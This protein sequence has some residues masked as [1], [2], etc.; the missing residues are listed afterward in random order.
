MCEYCVNKRNNNEVVDDTC[1]HDLVN[2]KFK[3]NQ[4]NQSNP[5]IGDVYNND[6]HRYDQKVIFEHYIKRYVLY[7]Y[8][9]NIRSQKFN[10]RIYWKCRNPKY[11]SIVSDVNK[12]CGID[13]KELNNDSEVSKI[14]DVALCSTKFNRRIVYKNRDGEFNIKLCDFEKYDEFSKEQGFSLYGDHNFEESELV[15]VGFAT[16]CLNGKLNFNLR[17]HLLKHNVWDPDVGAV[18]PGGYSSSYCKDPTNPV[19][20]VN[21]LID[22]IINELRAQGFNEMNITEANMIRLLTF[23][24]DNFIHRNDIDI[25]TDHRVHISESDEYLP[26]VDINVD[27]NNNGNSSG[28]NSYDDIFNVDSE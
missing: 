16:L 19:D 23:A 7:G 20:E 4:G 21:E 1:R 25:T 9:N 15:N 13:Y 3:Y 5:E 27:D 18:V 26:F 6:T 2:E 11:V 28:G 24:N 8:L 17:S 22:E 12:P 14:K 10:G